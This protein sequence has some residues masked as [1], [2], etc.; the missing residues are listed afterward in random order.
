MPADKVTG[1]NADPDFNAAIDTFFTQ[2]APALSAAP[3]RVLDG[4][5]DEE[6]LGLATLETLDVRRSA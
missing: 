5:L 2:H 1:W 6:A 3:I 4:D